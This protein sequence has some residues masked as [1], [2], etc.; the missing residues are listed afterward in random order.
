MDASAQRVRELERFYRR[1]IV[2]WLLLIFLISVAWFWFAVTPTPV[3]PPMMSFDKAELSGPS[4][5]CPGDILSY[6][7]DVHVNAPG[8][9]AIDVSVWRVTPPATVLFSDER[10]VVVTEPTEY[11]LDREWRIPQFYPDPRT[12]ELVP[13]LPGQ[14]E[15]RHALS[16]TSRATR[17]SLVAVPFTIRGDCHP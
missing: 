9:Y 1:Q 17:P 8:V 3:G 7:I 6:T 15:R 10:R 4:A 5:L 12:G 16:T 13:W 11:E 2:G 14:Y